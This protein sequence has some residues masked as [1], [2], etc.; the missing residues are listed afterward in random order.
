MAEPD[1]AAFPASLRISSWALGLTLAGVAGLIGCAAK[2]PDAI[3]LP[4]VSVAQVEVPP[5]KTE[6]ED[7][8]ASPTPPTLVVIDSGSADAPAEPQGLAEAAR[9]ERE[10]RAQ[11][12]KPIAVID[13]RNLAEF[14]KGQKLTVAEGVGAAAPE[15]TTSQAVDEAAAKAVKDE[16]YWRNRGLTIR[17]QWRE[18][19]D[20]IVELEGK[21]EALRRKFYAAD[22]PYV[23]DSQIK[24]DW[25]HTLDELDSTRREAERSA[26]EL[27]RFLNE[28]REAGAFPG[29]LREG[30]DI[31]PTPT[32]TKAVDA[33]PTEP[34]VVE[35]PRDKP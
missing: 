14:S 17:K 6:G 4:P 30:S 7:P 13:N 29:W 8:V 34:V 15:T 21:S 27:E 28:G 16:A 5:A 11:A 33:A 22:D 26:L 23:R 24:P 32:V 2:V 20:R 9:A 10:R 1:P 25:D 3:A 12:S 18:S 31:E 35:E 19:A